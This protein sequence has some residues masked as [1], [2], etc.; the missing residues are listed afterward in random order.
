MKRSFKEKLNTSRA[1]RPICTRVI[2]SIPTRARTRIAT[3]PEM[4]MIRMSFSLRVVM[5]WMPPYCFMQSRSDSQNPMRYIET[6]MEL[7]K[8]NIRPMAP[9]NSG[10]K[11]KGKFDDH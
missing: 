11:M 6:A 1:R 3:R 10:P 5:P 2:Q 9:P 7:A 4:P 8:K